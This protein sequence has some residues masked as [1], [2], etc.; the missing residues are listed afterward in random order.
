MATRNRRLINNFSRQTRRNGNIFDMLGADKD[1]GRRGL[2]D[3]VR[4]GL[5]SERD[6]INVFR[7]LTPR[8]EKVLRLLFAFGT[9]GQRSTVRE[10]A[11]EF[12]VTPGRIAGIRNKALARLRTVGVTKRFLEGFAEHIQSVRDSEPI[13]LVLPTT[14]QI[15]AVSADF[16]R[17][18][19]NL[20][21]NPDDLFLLDPRRF[22]EIV[23]EL[24]KRFGYEVELTCRTRDN[25]RDI[26]AVKRA[27]AQ[28]RYLIE[29][30]RHG[31]RNKVGVELVRGLYGVKAHEQATKAILATTSW[32]TRPAQEFFDAHRWEL[33]PRDHDGIIDWIERAENVQNLPS[34]SFEECPYSVRSR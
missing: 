30:K 15:I 14:D 28:V 21:R 12:D 18:I 7:I 24:W 6:L 17:L 4:Q 26:I 20:A 27:E 13:R 11:S 32:F 16:Q 19:Q 29:C 8:E 33:E 31:R 3:L 1:D 2:R 9:A 5:R 23:C 22:E 25:G 10:V 34:L